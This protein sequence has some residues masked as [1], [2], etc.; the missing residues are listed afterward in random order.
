MTVATAQAV[1]GGG[2]VWLFCDGAERYAVMQ[3]TRRSCRAASTSAL[4]RQ[5]ELAVANRS[6]GE[7]RN[8]CSFSPARYLVF[9]PLSSGSLR[10]LP[11]YCPVVFV[12][13]PPLQLNSCGVVSDWEVFSREKWE[14]W[15]TSSY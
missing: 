4:D 5:G 7:T 9:F 11:T 6:P 13:R 8:S 3:D 10:V 15:P 1:Q 14:M 2:G 12:A